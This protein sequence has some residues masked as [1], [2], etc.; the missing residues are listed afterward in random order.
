VVEG[1]LRTR[2]IRFTVTTSRPYFLPVSVDY[3]TVAGTATA[4]QDYKTKSG[5]VTIAPGSTSAAISVGVKGDRTVEPQEV[6]GVKIRNAVNATRWRAN[7]IGTIISDDRPATAASTTPRVSVGSAALVEGDS[8]LRPLRFAVTLS[9]ASA[10]EVE[11]EWHTT[12]GA[13]S[14]AS[15]FA[16]A[17]GDLT[18]PARAVSA[19]LLVPVS[20]DTVDEPNETFTLTLSDPTGAVIHRAV[21]TGTI[22]DDD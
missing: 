17:H 15:D 4:D 5:T 11:V 10:D 7:G 13:A 1:N 22:I 16:E 6:F 3:A 8:T 19:V 9:H 12:D 18:I 2:Q 14:S 20:P 21:G